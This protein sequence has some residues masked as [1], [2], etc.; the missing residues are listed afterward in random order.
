MA[1][2]YKKI[3]VME[4]KSSALQMLIAYLIGE[5]FRVFKVKDEN[6][7]LEIISKKRPD[8]VLLDIFEPAMDGMA[9]LKKL[10]ANSLG[11]D[12]PVIVLTN[13]E[14]LEDVGRALELGANA[15]LVKAS[16]SL[17]EVVEKIKQAL[18]E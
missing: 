16:Y 1:E 14:K 10:R 9:T 2:K 5:G 18:K 17:E 12:I 11:K 4:N 15:Y 7:G 13:L 8:L 6:K 3:L